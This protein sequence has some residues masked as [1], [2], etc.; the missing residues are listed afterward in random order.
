MKIITHAFFDVMELQKIIE[1]QHFYNNCQDPEKAKG[2]II[3]FANYHDATAKNIYKIAKSFFDNSFGSTSFDFFIT[4]LFFSKNS[5]DGNRSS[6][7]FTGA[8]TSFGSFTTVFIC[9]EY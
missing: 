1:K 6:R 2:K 7:D 9:S 4:I 3:A 5:F 8:I